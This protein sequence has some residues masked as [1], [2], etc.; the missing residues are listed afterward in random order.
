M[1]E[2]IFNEAETIALLKFHLN[3]Q[4]MESALSL[5]K[6]S[7]IEFPENNIIRF[8]LASVQSD[9]GLY[10]QAEQDYL[11][12]LD[13]DSEFH[14]ARFQLAL[15]Y[16]NITNRLLAIEQFTSIANST[17]ESFLNDFS[18]GFIQ[19]HENNIQSAK[20]YI[21]K[22]ITNNF[23]LPDLNKDIQN[24]I[25]SFDI[26]ST[27]EVIK[28]EPILETETITPAQLTKYFS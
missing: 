23:L 27:D 11:S 12:C 2:L 10:E 18:N 9:I 20:K 5:G 8:I 7:V 25:E 22:G 21:K 4:D 15:M 17:P 24:Y 28:D 19:I 26:S 3:K 1:T 16:W 6:R 14:L 13:V